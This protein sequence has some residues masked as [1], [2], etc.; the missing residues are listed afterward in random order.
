MTNSFTLDDIR[1]AADRKYGSVFIDDI[2]LVNPIRLSKKDRDALSAIQ[3]QLDVEDDEK[4]DVDQAEVFEDTIRLV[5]KTKAQ[6]NKLVSACGGD[7]AL[8]AEV[9]EHYNGGVQAGEA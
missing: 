4:L 9:M 2:E 3:A 5:A 8:L 6:G 7:L 1:A